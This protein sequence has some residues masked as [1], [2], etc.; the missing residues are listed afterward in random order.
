MRGQ[1]DVAQCL[2]NPDP[3]YDGAVMLH[4]LFRENIKKS[5]T[6]LVQEVATTLEKNYQA[7]LTFLNNIN[8]NQR[9]SVYIY[10]QYYSLLNYIADNNIHSC[11]QLCDSL[12]SELTDENLYADGLK[13]QTLQQERWEKDFLKDVLN[14]SEE[15][16]KKIDA[17]KLANYKKYIR[18]AIEVI[19]KSDRD[20][21]AELFDYTSLICLLKVGS[22]HYFGSSSSV[23]YF[24]VLLITSPSDN[25]DRLLYFF[26]LIIHEASHLHLNIV[27]GLD[28]VVLND[29]NE[30][31]YSPAR[32]N[33]RRMKGIFH[34]HFVF[35]RLI[36]I[37]LK[38]WEYLN[39]TNVP[40]PENIPQKDLDA[41]ISQQPWEYKRRLVAWIHKFKRGEEVIRKHAKLTEVGQQL[42]DNMSKNFVK[43]IKEL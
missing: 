31:F 42:F 36:L 30:V 6:L 40:L 38:A 18:K 20:M 12:C 17:I 28:P 3:N 1:H 43:V 34:A 41:G 15:D 7:L 14:T 25:I 11:E 22:A 23:K 21:A 32:N 27:M 39:P 35:Y 19:K 10:Y 16:Y 37:Y 4:R 5:F 26:D 33:K 24:G 29:P 9:Y 8:S 13:I 2:I